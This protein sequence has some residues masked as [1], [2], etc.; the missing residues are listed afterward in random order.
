M[1]ELSPSEAV[2][3]LSRKRITDPGLLCYLFGALNAAAQQETKWTVEKFI[4]F[5]VNE[6]RAEIEAQKDI[7]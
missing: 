3:L 2:A 4:T 7:L 5:F 6:R 1:D